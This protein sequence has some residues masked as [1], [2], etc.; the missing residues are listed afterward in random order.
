MQGQLGTRH[1]YTRTAFQPRH[2]PRP[3]YIQTGA[4]PGPRKHPPA[5]RIWRRPSG[6]PGLLPGGEVALHDVRA[7]HL[8]LPH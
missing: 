6:L 5:L 3:L 7:P 2:L 4:S 1:Q 8:V